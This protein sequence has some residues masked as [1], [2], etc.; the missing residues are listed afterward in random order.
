MARRVGGVALD[1]AKMNGERHE[2]YPALDGL[3]GVAVWIVL[4]GHAG[5][6]RSGGVGVDIFFTLSGFLITG[7]L[8][9]ELEATQTLRVRDF[10]V[11]RFLRL[12]PCLWL[13]VVI[14]VAFNAV[15][16]PSSSL[17]PMQDCR[18]PTR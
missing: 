10:Y 16:A 18:C 4:L 3:R 11:R 14:V 2:Y 5:A 13:T 6:M 1:A 8:L 15:V 17:L 12:L 9:N 7:I